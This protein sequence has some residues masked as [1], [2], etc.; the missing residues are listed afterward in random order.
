[1]LLAFVVAS[2]GLVLARLAG[3]D[4][5]SQALGLGARQET[6]ERLR[7]VEGLDR[8]FVQQYVSWLE[9]VLRFDFGHSLLFQRPVGP[10]VISRTVNSAILAIGALLLACGVGLPMGVF[11]GSGSGG[12]RQTVRAISI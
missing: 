1:M 5:V 7:A 4:Y 11:S 2:G 10:L 8:P 12:A 6:V 9:G 3:G